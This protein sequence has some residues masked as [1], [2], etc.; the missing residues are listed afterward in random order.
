MKLLHSLQRGMSLVEL[1]VAMFISLFLTA[2]L[3]SMFSMSSSNVTT[4]S[5]FNQLQENGRIALTLM[6][7]DINQLGFF[8]DLTGT[9]MLVNVN[10]TNTATNV[11]SD[12][13]GAGINN[14]TFPV[15]VPAHF[16]RLWGF[17]YKTTVDMQ[18]TSALTPDKGTDVLQIK[19]LMGPASTPPLESNRYYASVTANEIHFFNGSDTPPTTLNSRI[20]EYQHHVYFVETD[21]RIPVLKRRSLNI[22]KGMSNEEQLV[23]GI[24]NVRVLYGFDNDGDSTPDAFMPAEDV[25]NFMWDNQ[26]FQR[27]VAVKIFVLVR[28]I[29]PDR[30]YTND[31]TY[32]LGDKQISGASSSTNSDPD[33]DHYRRRVMSTTVVLE[34]PVLIRS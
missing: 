13:V 8:G 3:F 12:C 19:R 23:E 28:S 1:M 32:T 9:E 34:N 30:S 27:L 5:Q 7:R 4:T 16:R 14:E 15:D 22:S 11:T 26:G 31:V 2:G 29:Q 10:T 21:N 17:E 33:Y 6:E 24:E 18:C 20:W 25:S